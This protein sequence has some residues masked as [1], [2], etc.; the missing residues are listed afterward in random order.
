[1][2][3]TKWNHLRNGEEVNRGEE[4]PKVW[5]L[6]CKLLEGG[7]VRVNDWLLLVERAH[8]IRENTM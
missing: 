7:G 1:M 5:V 3:N 6:V 4:D 2:E 8:P